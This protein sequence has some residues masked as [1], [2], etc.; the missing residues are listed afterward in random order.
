MPNP[1]LNSSRTYFDRG[2]R[3]RQSIAVVIPAID[4]AATIGP[5]VRR[6]RS[7]VPVVYVLDGGSSDGTQAVARAA[8]AVVIGCHRP[9]LGAAI[10]Q[11]IDADLAEV[12]VFLDADG[13]HCPED[14]PRM[15][16]PVLRGEADLVI[17]DR[18]EGGSAELQGDP[19]HW[20]RA[21]GT[22]VLQRMVNRRL[23]TRLNDIQNGFRVIRGPVA[24]GL[25]LR[26]DGFC[27]CQ[28]TAVRCLQQGR[29]VLNLPSFELRRAHGRPRL[30]LWAVWPRF[31]WT[32]CWWL[33]LEPRNPLR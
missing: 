13:S 23:G 16:A 5:L 1:L 26:E 19:S 11:A 27:I 6:C 25:G 9:G 33:W 24:Q 15:M 10:R 4:E 8:G 17:A 28:E 3:S 7:F 20:P 21:F 30:R 12:L 22:W 31:I 29:R 2:P 32:M 14:I 18:I